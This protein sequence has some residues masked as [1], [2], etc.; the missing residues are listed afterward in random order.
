M[1]HVKVTGIT[2]GTLF[3]ND[4]T[5]PIGNGAFITFAQGAAGLRFT[6]ATNSVATGHVTV[7]ASTRAADAGLGGGTVTATITVSGRILTILA[8]LTFGSVPSGTTRSLTMR[9][10]NSGGAPLTVTGITYPT[11]VSGDWAGGIIAPGTTQDVTVTFAPTAV[12]TYGGVVT[13]LANQ[14]SGQTTTPVTG[15]GTSAEPVVTEHPQNVAVPPGATAH[16]HAAAVGNPTPTVQW[17]VSLNGGTTWSDISGATADAYTVTPALAD[18]GHQFRAVFTNS[19]GTATT[20]AATLRVGH[21]ARADLDGDGLSDLVVWQPATGT[22][23]WVLSSKGYVDDG[24]GTKQWGNSSLGDVPLLG[25]LDGDGKADLIVWR[26]S[27]GTWYWLTSS[28]GYSY[29]SASGKQWG[30]LSLGD[31]PLV[32]DL[33][34]DGRDDLAV[35]RASTGTWVLAPVSDRLR[36][37]QRRREAVGQCESRRP[38]ACRGFRR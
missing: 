3:Q 29:A 16:F 34:G 22:W 5:T 17:Q 1:T 12:T 7:Q 33:D 2:G 15:T 35:W 23:S 4:G 21:H 18:S 9:L 38:A 26:A 19:A 32:A 31:Q 14:T 37:C 30:N 6:P 36:L 10:G 20:N 11:N 13:I 8:D 27:T 28:T 25:D 24:L